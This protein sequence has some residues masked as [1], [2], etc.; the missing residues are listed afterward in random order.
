MSEDGMTSSERPARTPQASLNSP[1][2]TAPR[3]APDRNTYTPT[4]A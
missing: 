3:K 1:A 2:R 4:I